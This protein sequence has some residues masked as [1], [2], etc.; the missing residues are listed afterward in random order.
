M[1]KGLGRETQVYKLFELVNMIFGSV[2]KEAITR[3][4][5]C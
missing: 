3:R 1:R 2:W 5:G 4:G